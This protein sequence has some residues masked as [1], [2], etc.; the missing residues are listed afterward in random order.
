MPLLDQETRGTTLCRLGVVDPFHDVYQVILG[1]DLLKPYLPW[2]QLPRPDVPYTCSM[3]D[4]Q[5][6]I[7]DSEAS[8]SDVPD[9]LS[10]CEPGPDPVKDTCPRPQSAAVVTSDGCPTTNLPFRPIHGVTGM[11][12]PH[13]P[14]TKPDATF[15]QRST[16]HGIQG[17]EVATVSSLVSEGEGGGWVTSSDLNYSLER[18]VS[19]A[20]I[21]VECRA[22]NSVRDAVVKET[23]VISVIKPPGRPSLQV[24]GVG[25]VVA[26]GQLVV[27]CSSA[28]GNPHPGVTIYKGHEKLLTE[29][30][31]DGRVTIARAVTEV[32]PSDN[33]AK[34]SC[35]VS[36]PATDAPLVATTPIELFFPPW[37]VKAG[38]SPTNVSA[39]QVAKLICESSSSLPAS[40]I[41]WRSGSV[42]NHGATSMHSR[43]SMEVR[44]T[45]YSKSGKTLFPPTPTQPPS[46]SNQPTSHPKVLN[47]KIWNFLKVTLPNEC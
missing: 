36:N 31:V 1:R 30:T 27:K 22:Y 3:P 41:T 10:I 23:R 7:L 13:R 2:T 8:A 20:E 44:S 34:I 39:G 37:E 14:E 45:R 46:T 18:S 15:L 40:T 19:L 33:G 12:R 38:V 21:S 5:P 25:D 35:Q 4:N 16:D 28:G 6:S 17:V 43:G 9:I 32:T 24:E 29:V 47:L 26:G 11:P 42:T